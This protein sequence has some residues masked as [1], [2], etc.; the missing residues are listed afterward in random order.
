MFFGPAG[1]ALLLQAAAATPTPATTLAD[2]PPPRLTVCAVA[3]GSAAPVPGATVVL[4]GP[5]GKALAG[6]SG[7][8]GCAIFPSLDVGAWKVTVL[9]AGTSPVDGSVQITAAGGQTFTAKLELAASASQEM[10]VEASRETEGETRRS[11][12]PEEIR[13]VAGSANDAL[14]SVQNM[15]G[16]ARSSFGVNMLVVRGAAPGD[17]RVLLDGQEIP[18]LYHFEGIRSVFPTEAISRID[19]LPGGFGVRY[20]RAIGGVVDVETRPARGDRWG[21]FF[22][23]DVYD[24]AGLAEGPVG[25]HAKNG[26]MLAA[27]RRSYIDAILPAVAPQQDL[28]WTVAPRYYDYQLRYDLPTTEGGTQ[29]HVMAYGSDDAL[30]FALKKIDASGLRGNYLFRTAFH[31]IQA[32][33]VHPLGNG[34]IAT[35]DP[36]IGYQNIALDGAGAVVLGGD[37]TSGGL[38]LETGGPLVSGVN[39]LLGIDA[40]STSDSYHV[41]YLDDGGTG[42]ATPDRRQ[43]ARAS[44]TSVAGG[45]FAEARIAASDR[46]T[47]VPGM[48]VDYYAPSH[49]ASF[50][51]RIAARLSFD[52]DNWGKA[53]AGLYHQPPEFYQWDAKIGNPG[54]DLPVALQAGVGGGRRLS[55]TTSIEG[56]AFYKWLDRLVVRAQ[57]DPTDPTARTT[58]TNAGIG[59]VYGLELLARRDFSEK[60]WGWVSYTLSKSE[61][62]APDANGWS[63]YSLDQTHILTVVAGRKLRRNWQLGARFRY[64]TG[65]PTTVVNEAVYDSDSDHYMP[66][67]GFRH[68]ERLPPFHQLDLRIDKRW[69]WSGWTLD[70]YFDVQNVYGHQNPEQLRYSF[71]YSKSAYVTGL[72]V[73]PSIG[74]RGEF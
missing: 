31:R 30:D 29:A 13:S 20:G 36:S 55:A 35:L 41:N 43:V 25:A 59:R 24:A 39:L 72:P 37:R 69:D 50:D 54:L 34:W 68:E 19:F 17:T 73:L 40:L 48:R 28:T 8:D 15:P 56:E 2:A 27:V 46:L 64:V 6:K 63:P 32:P 16:V 10:V 60:L 52:R 47:I 70:A 65:N 18:Q 11:I 53:Y 1:I 57:G 71:D 45:A 62:A 38:R 12:T 66:V 44:Y 14:K 5:D 61:R 58:W 51:P 4:V 67:P 33:V 7:V 9:A 3:G 49:H 42:A 22:D 23:A 74:V 21:G 26:R